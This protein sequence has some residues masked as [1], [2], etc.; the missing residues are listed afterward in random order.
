MVAMT[1]KRL[2][3][4]E[5]I[6]STLLFRNY[7]VNLYQIISNKPQSTFGAFPLIPFE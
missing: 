1:M 3:I 4:V 5:S 7:V 2:Q 6:L